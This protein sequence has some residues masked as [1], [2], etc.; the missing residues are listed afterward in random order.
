L[1]LSNGDVFEGFFRDGE[2]YEGTYQYNN[3]DIYEGFWLKDLKHGKGK[4]LQL[5]N[6]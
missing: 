1:T 2:R 4:K 5:Q 6:G 3:G